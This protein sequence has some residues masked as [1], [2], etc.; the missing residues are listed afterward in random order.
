MPTNL[1]RAFRLRRDKLIKNGIKLKKIRFHD[2]RHTHA[3]LLFSQ[4]EHPKVVQ[5]RLGHSSIE[6]TL[7]TYSHMLLNMQESAVQTLDE[8]FLNLKNA[9]F[10]NDVTNT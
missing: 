6:V 3:S 7:D 9:D 2:L 5:E 10:E 1:G 4:K 8:M